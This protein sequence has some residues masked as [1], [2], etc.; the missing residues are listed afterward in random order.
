MTGPGWGEDRDSSYNWDQGSQTQEGDVTD[1]VYDE[2]GEQHEVSH[3][4]YGG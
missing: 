4:D 3:E 1:I 2:D